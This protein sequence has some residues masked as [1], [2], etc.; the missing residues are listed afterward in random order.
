R[1]I[2]A[3]VGHFDSAVLL[4]DA[5]GVEPGM[6]LTI[7][8]DEE[9]PYDG[10][11]M[12]QKGTITQVLRRLDGNAIEILGSARDNYAL[13]ETV[14]CRFFRPGTCRLKNITVRGFDG[15]AVEDVIGGHGISIRHADHPHL[16]SI[17]VSY[18]SSTGVRV[19]GSLY[20]V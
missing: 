9:W 13:S 15:L 16:E 11:G 14:T 1:T 12:W 7:T 20:P 6:I 8:S 3:D 18:V 17:D 19:A 5:S 2:A 4:D 10:R